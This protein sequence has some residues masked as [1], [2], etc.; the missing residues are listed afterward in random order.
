M[1]MIK[2]IFHRC[3]R[4]LCFRKGIYGKIGISNH[5]SNGVYIYENAVIGNYNY[6]SPYSIVNNA[7]IGNYC[8]IGPNCMIGLGEH[9]LH[10]ISTNTR[11]S[12][13][14]GNMNLFEL[15]NTVIENDVWLG[16][17]CVVKQGVKISNGA[18]VGANAVVTHDV[19]PYAI[20]VG[21]PAKIIAYRFDKDKIDEIMQSNWYNEKIENAR[22]IVLKLKK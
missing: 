5:F 17:S 11:I 22:K 1:K 12:N 6:F 7:H 19:P 18:V 4:M 8:S 13:G 21:V 20:V 10:A 14:Y 9:D 2:M 15:K 16:A 3:F